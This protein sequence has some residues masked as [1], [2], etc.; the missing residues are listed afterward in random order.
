M[1]SA[2]MAVRR[3]VL[4]RIGGLEALGPFLADDHTL[5]ELVAKDGRSVTLCPYTVSTAVSE[6]DIGELCSHELRWARTKRAQ[7]P[8]GYAF[9]FVM[10]AVP[11]AL[12]LLLIAP[13]W[14]SLTIFIYVVVLRW[15]LHVASRGA[16]R[17]RRPS[18][19]WLMPLR[20]VLSLTIW[21]VSMFGRTVKWRDA[22]S[23]VSPDGR[24]TAPN[25]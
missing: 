12:A 2:T 8:A 9:S 11:F 16:L 21:F 22:T 15:C 18:K 13:G 23:R 6:T 14:P 20:D 5:G 17:N 4:E 19:W 25:P 1:A 10:Y 3:S 24:M 7:A